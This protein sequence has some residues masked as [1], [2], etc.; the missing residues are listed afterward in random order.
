MSKLTPE[1]VE[2][3]AQQI[4]VSNEQRNK[5]IAMISYMMADDADD[6]PKE[7][8]VKKQFVFVLSDPDGRYKKECG[9]RALI[10]WVVQIPE[11]DSPHTAPDK[12][13][14]A[15]HH[16]NT[17]KKGRML[18]AQTIGESCEVIPSRILK[19]Q[20]VWVKTKCAIYARPTSNEIQE[21]P[22]I[23]GSDRG[24]V[25][26]PFAK[27]LA[28]EGVKSLTVTIGEKSVKFTK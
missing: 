24:S 14:E 16:F 19:E 26:N 15:A 6:E 13:R 3:A 1:L 9:E 2:K 18:P 10:G 22:S 23:L 4:G 17:T 12:I 27:T 5:L 7:P 21:T 28:H 11:S 25:N 20:G 8:A